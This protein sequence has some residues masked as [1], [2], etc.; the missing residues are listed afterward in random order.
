MQNMPAYMCD[1]IKNL[2]PV[3]VHLYISSSINLN[4][5]MFVFASI[6]IHIYKHFVDFGVGCVMSPEQCFWFFENTGVRTDLSSFN[7]HLQLG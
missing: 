5:C 6:G 3:S 2:M 7:I 4:V 1:G